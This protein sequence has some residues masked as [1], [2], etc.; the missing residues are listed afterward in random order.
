MYIENEKITAFFLQKSRPK[1]A[2]LLLMLAT[3]ALLGIIA[4]I[5]SL[6]VQT[7][8][9][10]SATDTTRGWRENAFK[11][12]TE[13]V[14]A[15]IT[16][17]PEAPQ[18]TP[19]NCTTPWITLSSSATA[20]VE[21]RIA[22]KDTALIPDTHVPADPYSTRY[23]A[24]VANGTDGIHPVYDPR[25]TP[26]DTLIKICR[27]ICFPYGVENKTADSMAYAIAD[28]CD[29]NHSLY[30]SDTTGIHG[31]EGISIV[32]VHPGD[33]R[34]IP[35][36]ALLRQ[37]AFYDVDTD[38]NSFNIF[39]AFTID[40]AQPIVVAPGK[41][42]TQIHL[43]SAPYE[44]RNTT[45][46]G[47]KKAW[48]TFHSL[49]Q[50]CYSTRFIPHQFSGIRADMHMTCGTYGDSVEIID[51]DG[52]YLYIKGYPHATCK[53][54]NFI[55]LR[56][57]DDDLDD[58]SLSFSHV[59]DVVF[60][61]GLYP[62]VTYNMRGYSASPRKF[63]AWRTPQKCGDA[64]VKAGAVS[65]NNMPVW[66]HV[67][68]FS[69]SIAGGNVCCELTAVKSAKY[70]G[71]HCQ[72]P[73]QCVVQNNA[74]RSVIV[75]GFSLQR[76]TPKGIH[77]TFH[78]D[79][80]RLPQK[81]TH[82]EKNPA[83]LYTGDRLLIQG[84]YATPYPKNAEI[85]SIVFAPDRI[86][87]PFRVKE[88]IQEHSP[89]GGVAFRIVCDVDPLHV[90]KAK[91]WQNACVYITS[92]DAASHIAFSLIS[93]DSYSLRV[94]VGPQ[95]F[96]Q[97]YMP[98]KGD[99]IRI[100]SL[101]DSLKRTPFHVKTPFNT[102]TATLSVP[103]SFMTDNS[104]YMSQ[105]NEWHPTAYSKVFSITSENTST[106]EY[107][108]VPNRIAEL[109]IWKK[110]FSHIGADSA[111]TLALTL[112]TYFITDGY[113]YNIADMHARYA[114]SQW[115]YT[116]MPV[117]S[118]NNSSCTI[119]VPHDIPSDFFKGW[120]VSFTSNDISRVY[121]SH[122]SVLEMYHMPD[123]S[124]FTSVTLSPYGTDAGCIS[125]VSHATNLWQWTIP[126]DI[127]LPADVVLRG[128]AEMNTSA[129]ARVTVAIFHP[130]HKKWNTR[131]NE[132]QFSQRGTLS[133]GTLTRDMLDKNGT[134]TIRVIADT[135]RTWLQ[136]IYCIPKGHA[137]GKT[138]Y[139]KRRS[140]AFLAQLDVR[141]HTPA[142][143]EGSFTRHAIVQRDWILQ[144]GKLYPHLHIQR[145]YP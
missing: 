94:H 143:S 124:Q 118:R 8:T 19:L 46:P 5:W 121:T 93:H 52:S 4:V 34:I 35:A 132:K 73:A 101:T 27:K 53:K 16:A 86:G 67:K 18:N 60:I 74:Q 40:D 37:S 30:S 81:R 95:E 135:P 77:D 56:L 137:G 62:H 100:G 131:V 70:A 59:T 141:M 138:R 110:I 12:A 38:E 29:D 14:E 2:A 90:W 65:T 105:N 120:L 1:G 97:T 6:T 144:E 80:L 21:Y 106:N 36:S 57:L 134:L 68:T 140:D 31:D 64:D 76:T 103:D 125:L 79:S 33:E 99:I 115:L 7:A 48:D 45:K 50:S 26:L 114:S 78:I 92:A 122:D 72:H 145:I 42:N 49:W 82:R 91:R 71:F 28:A 9:K 136:G 128:S 96:A 17:G 113:A 107:E 41:T 25:V 44:P 129:T 69:S 142:R 126:P 47:W 20:H 123:A 61:T 32:A 66:Q 112:D 130:F 55:T 108:S 87:T 104:W 133:C 3:L 84:S 111:R 15:L 127:V 75:T 24:R 63:P 117:V 98:R 109:P 83:T 88:C 11:S 58:G 10:T 51:N 139:A 85:P 119:D 116:E 13:H 23:A 39:H 54:D 89:Y 43:S 22:I 102:S